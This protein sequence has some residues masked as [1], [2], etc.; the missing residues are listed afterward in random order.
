MSSQ[1]LPAA[2][3][4]PVPSA[5]STE[6]TVF[7]PVAGSIRVTDEP[8]KWNAQTKPPPKTSPPGRG[9]TLTRPA[10][11]FVRGSIRATT[12][13]PSRATQMLPPAATAESR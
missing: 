1:T 7:V 13:A 12:L 2:Y 3:A 5:P 6:K 9:S 8:W 10:I 11:R 4:I